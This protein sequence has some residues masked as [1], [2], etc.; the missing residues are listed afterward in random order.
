MFGGSACSVASVIACPVVDERTKH[1]N[2]Y[3]DNCNKTVINVFGAK[4]VY[5]VAEY[6][7]GETDTFTY[8][9]GLVNSEWNCKFCMT[10]VRDMGKLIGKDGVFLCKNEEGA[11]QY[12]RV[13]MISWRV[14]RKKI[15]LLKII[16]CV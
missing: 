10:R 14:L 6:K 3:M 1:F 16:S 9:D 7:G 13:F 5:Y 15:E 4:G 8:I 12:K 2:S 11:V